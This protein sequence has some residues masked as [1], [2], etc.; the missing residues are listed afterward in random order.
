MRPSAKPPLFTGLSRKSP[1]TAP[2]TGRGESPV[3]ND[4]GPERVG[5]F[6][7]V[8]TRRSYCPRPSARLACP[9]QRALL[10]HAL[11]NYERYRSTSHRHLAL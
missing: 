1:T 2:E 5:P 4:E 11:T 8:S 6:V 7:G 10:S 9:R 3:H